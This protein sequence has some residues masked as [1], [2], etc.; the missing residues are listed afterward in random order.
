VFPRHIAEALRD[1]RPVEPENH[2]CVTIFFSD[3]VDF[4][5]ISAEL[6]PQKVSAMLHRLFNRLDALAEKHQVFKVETIG[7][8]WMGVTNCVADQSKD[9]AKRIALFALDAVQAANKTMIDEDD[10]KLGYLSIRSG[11]HSGPVL[12]NVIG[13]HT[14]RYSLF[15]D[16]VNTASRMESNSEPNRIQCSKT[17][18]VLLQ[19][20]ATM[21]KDLTLC[22]RGKIHI[23][24][25]GEMTT[26]WVNPPFVI[27]SSTDAISVD[28]DT[29]V[30]DDDTPVD[31]D[32]MPEGNGMLLE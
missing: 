16:T 13:S 10:P 21:P 3:V 31:D 6:D 11:L 12:T 29:P 27:G 1:G 7:D 28:N 24:G 18:A 14:P 17:C 30:D 25:K 4:T 22:R 5:A 20:Q 23:K 19:Q 9:H 15:G 2:A 8:A 26:Y 32:D